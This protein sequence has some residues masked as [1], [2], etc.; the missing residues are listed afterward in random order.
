MTSM[1]NFYF[2]SIRYDYLR[3]ERCENNSFSDTEWLPL[4]LREVVK[5]MLCIVQED[6]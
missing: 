1:E 3:L 4:R 5:D 6:K 2:D